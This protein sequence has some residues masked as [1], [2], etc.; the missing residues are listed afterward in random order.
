ML[1][2]SLDAGLFSLAHPELNW[3]LGNLQLILRCLIPSPQ[4]TEH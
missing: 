3:P 1:H 4:E 2:A